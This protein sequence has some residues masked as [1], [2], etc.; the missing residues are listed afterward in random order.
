MH[1]NQPHWE[2]EECYLKYNLK[3]CHAVDVKLI[4]LIA[5]RAR[6]SHGARISPAKH[7]LRPLLATEYCFYA[8][9]L[10]L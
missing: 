2:D 6:A 5:L 9:G 4:A 8:C 3:P 10:P 1:N 7:K